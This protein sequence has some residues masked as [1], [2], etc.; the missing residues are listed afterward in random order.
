MIGGKGLSRSKSRINGKSLKQ[1]VLAPT[2]DAVLTGVEALADGRGLLLIDVGGATTDVYSV[3]PRAQKDEKPEDGRGQG[4]AGDWLL[5]RTVEGD[6]GVRSGALGVVEAALAEGLV[7]VEEAR[8]LTLYGQEQMT[9]AGLP[10]DG[11][12]RSGQESDDRRRG[13][14]GSAGRENVQGMQQV[15][16]AELGSGEAEQQDGRASQ[17]NDQ[18]LATWPY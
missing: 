16:R 4:A 18:R 12:E 15:D 7:G 5:A 11:G 10:G 3:L 9:A 2:P 8:K 17:E 14:H 1:L 6:L 13:A